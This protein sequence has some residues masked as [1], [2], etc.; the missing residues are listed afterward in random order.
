MLYLALSSFHVRLLGL[1]CRG[2]IVVKQIPAGHLR[3]LAQLDRGG[4][5]SALN[6]EIDLGGVV[7]GALDR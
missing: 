4:I 3:A 2:Q 5:A 6:L 1:E 7:S